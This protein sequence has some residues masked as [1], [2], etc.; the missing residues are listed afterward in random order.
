MIVKSTYR[1]VL[2]GEIIEVFEEE[3]DEKPADPAPVIDETVSQI[4]Q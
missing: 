1:N 3:P 4:P 2:T